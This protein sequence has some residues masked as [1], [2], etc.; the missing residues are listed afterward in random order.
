MST[1]IAASCQRLYLGLAARFNYWKMVNLCAA[2]FYDRVY[3]VSQHREVD[4]V[5]MIRLIKIDGTPRHFKTRTT[6]CLELS[7]VAVM[8]QTVC[9]ETVDTLR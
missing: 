1:E 5:P 3:L 8:K 9:G 2:R 4:L 6:H 7:L